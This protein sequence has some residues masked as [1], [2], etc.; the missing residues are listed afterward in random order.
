MTTIGYN[1][2]QDLVDYALARGVTID[3]ADAS[4]LLT[5]ALDWLELR[6]FK[7][8]KTD[9]EQPLEFPRNG[10]EDVPERIKTAQ[11]VCA[12]LYL[13]GYDP[14]AV[15]EPQVTQETVFGAVSVSYNPQGRSKPKF[16]YLDG[17][18][19]PFLA[20]GGEGANQFTVSAG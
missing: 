13:N 7:G 10:S 4:V 1:E 18:L 6:P 17:L 8:G 2:P 16:G 15:D 14:L 3:L 9:P 19:K 20:S 11:K 12:M 5:R